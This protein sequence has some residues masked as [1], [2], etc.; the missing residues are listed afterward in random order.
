MK[1]RIKTVFWVPLLTIMICT[2][3]TSADENG[4]S[5]Q[6]LANELVEGKKELKQQLEQAIKK[7]DRQIAGLKKKSEG[8]SADVGQQLGSAIRRLQKERQQIIQQLE[9]VAQASD[10]SWQ[11]VKR[12]SELAISDA[13]DAF[14]S[15]SRKISEFLQ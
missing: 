9:D 6:Q 5:P 8:A 2:G 11:D 7:A 1:A 14:D 4:K 10:I 15:L 12:E 3:C 13:S